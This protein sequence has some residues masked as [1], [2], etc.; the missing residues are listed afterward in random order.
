MLLDIEDLR[1]CAAGHVPGAISLPH[2]KIVSSRMREIAER[3]FFITYC[4]GPHCNGAASAIQARS[5]ASVKIM[6]GGITGWIEQELHGG[7]GSCHDSDARNRS[8]ADTE[9]WGP[10]MN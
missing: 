2:G 4:A 5:T 10:K 9:V 8:T 7:N 3:P 1:S 6:A